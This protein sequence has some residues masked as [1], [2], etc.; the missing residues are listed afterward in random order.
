MLGAIQCKICKHWDSFLSHCKEEDE[1]EEEEE[2]E[3]ELPELTTERKEYGD[4]LE[5]EEEME[6]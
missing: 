4:R 6:G 2:V 1:M 5:E 3:K